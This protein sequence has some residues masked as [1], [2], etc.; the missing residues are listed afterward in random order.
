MTFNL[1]DARIHL[2][3]TP[4]MLRAFLEPLPEAW[5]HGDEGPGTWSPAQVL[6]HLI[7]CEVDDWVPRAERILQHGTA[8]PFSPFDRTGGES[9]YAD[10]SVPE[11]L[12]EFARARAESLAALD[13]LA[14]A[15]QDLERTGTH[16]EFGA[17]TLGQLLS[18]WV[19]HDL[20]HVVQIS[21]ALARQYR[22][23][24]GPWQKYLRVVQ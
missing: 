14:I 15:E 5:L 20:T 18:T 13:R 16:P 7:W 19:V 23:A 2:G 6:R 11:L 24:V 1:A 22:E 3:R 10:L 9:R 8:V 4:A 17:V 21:R 12:T